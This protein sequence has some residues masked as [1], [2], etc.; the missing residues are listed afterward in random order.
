MADFCT[1]CSI[2]MWG[3]EIAPDINV[4]QI[5]SELKPDH[6]MDVLCEG[7]GM[8]AIGKNGAGE[9]Y[10]AILDGDPIDRVSNFVKWITLDEYEQL[11]TN[12]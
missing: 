11:K 6:Y 7:C 12:Q 5:I 2:E 9:V 3:E 1:R 4:E 8:A 10:I